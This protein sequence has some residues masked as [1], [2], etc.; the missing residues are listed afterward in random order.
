M[1]RKTSAIEILQAL[2]RKT[3]P[4]TC[5]RLS[6]RM[7]RNPWLV[8]ASISPNDG[9]RAAETATYLRSGASR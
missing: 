3:E 4:K 8:V 6:A 1:A 5:L 7:M 9:D 2:P